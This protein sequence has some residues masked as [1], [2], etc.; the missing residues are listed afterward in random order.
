MAITKNGRAAIAA[1]KGNEDC[2][3][4]LRGGKE[5]NYDAASVAQASA[6]IARA[7]MTPHLMIDA[8]HANSRKRPENQPDVIADVAQQV[9]AGNRGIMGVM[10]ESNLV[11][12]RQ[13]LATGAPLVYGQSVTDGCIDW[14][15]TVT[16]LEAL[17]AAARARR[18]AASAGPGVGAP[19]SV[20]Q[21]Q[22]GGLR[23]DQL[24]PLSNE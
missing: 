12:G 19:K 10:V 16:A 11:A 7:G 4:I 18:R 1:T 6:E 14:A 24:A 15:T 9:A 3:V 22:S 23:Q 2:H 5:P 21:R 8:S 20:G 17:A 13:E